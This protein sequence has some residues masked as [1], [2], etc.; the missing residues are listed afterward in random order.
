M[1]RIPGGKSS[2]KKDLFPL[3]EKKLEKRLRYP[4]EIQEECGL[5]AQRGGR[6][7]CSFRGRLQLLYI[8]S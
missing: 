5:F 6:L 2:K 8:A 3:R 1:R 7:P 4:L